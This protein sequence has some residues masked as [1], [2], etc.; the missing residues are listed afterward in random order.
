MFS[1]QVHPNRIADAITDTI[2]GREIHESLGIE[3]HYADW[4]KRQIKTLGLIENIDFIV[5]HQQGKNP[6]GGRPT[7]EYYFT[8]ESAK[9]VALASRTEKGR[10]Y[11]QALIDLENQVSGNILPDVQNPMFK[12]MLDQTKQ[13]QQLIIS[14]DRAHQDAAAAK[15]EAEL[16]NRRALE[17]LS[18]QQWVTI[19]Q[20]V[21][22]HQMTRHLPPGTEQ[23]QY[24]RW[25]SG[26]CR[27]KGLPT[28]KQQSEQYQEWAYPV[29][30]I[31]QTLH[32]WLARRHGQGNIT[33]LEIGDGGVW[34]DTTE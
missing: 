26:Y 2:C 22:I 14:V 15:Q 8:I 11:R 1:I 24:G 13:M 30:T 3:K 28:Y 29:W 5:F 34:Y 10:Q 31:Q 20:Y 6:L 21:A 19:R 4:I 16:A 33:D 23:Q 12:L 17:A 7:I 18:A 9:H 27:E 25:L 32:A